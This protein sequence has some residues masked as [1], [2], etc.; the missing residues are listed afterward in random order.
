MSEMFGVYRVL[1]NGKQVYVSRTAT[2]S[3][4]LAEDIAADFTAGRYVRPDGTIGKRIARPH[5]AKR[6]GG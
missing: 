6:I 4:R 5:I 3:Q 2:G 1:K